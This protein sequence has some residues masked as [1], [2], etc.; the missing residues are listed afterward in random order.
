MLLYITCLYSY[1]AYAYALNHESFIEQMSSSEGKAPGHSDGAYGV[2]DKR[3]N[4]K[5]LYYL[6][7][8][9]RKLR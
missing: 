6:Q 1:N 2:V 5:S 4:G 3:H 9:Q 7:V 8:H